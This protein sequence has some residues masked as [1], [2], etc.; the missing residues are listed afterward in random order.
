MVSFAA[1]FH[2]NCSLF[3]S[4][5]NRVFENHIE[6]KKTELDVVCSKSFGVLVTEIFTIK[7]RWL[8]VL[9]F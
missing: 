4:V 9:L 5:L 3:F 1:I 6:R 7:S 2:I 8:F